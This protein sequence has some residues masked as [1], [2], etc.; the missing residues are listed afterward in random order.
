MLH[1][2]HKGWAGRVKESALLLSME[3]DS[4]KLKVQTVNIQATS[5][6]IKSS[7]LKMP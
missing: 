6:M 3:V 7:V 4:A 5:Q 1:Q 2:Q